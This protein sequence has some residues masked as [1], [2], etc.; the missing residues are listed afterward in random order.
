MLKA[1]SFR[2]IGIHSLFMLREDLECGMELRVRRAYTKNLAGSADRHIAQGNPAF[3]I[4]HPSSI[5]DVGQRVRLFFVDTVNPFF[6][7]VTPVLMI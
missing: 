1:K 6:R 3:R 4:I 2:F 7:R 5:Y